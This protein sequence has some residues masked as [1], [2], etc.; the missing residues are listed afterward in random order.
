MHLKTR[1]SR[2]I[3]SDPSEKPDHLQGA[4]QALSHLKRVRL[5]FLFVFAPGDLHTYHAHKDC[6][7]PL[8]EACLPFDRAF[9]ISM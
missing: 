1:R 9:S 5:C 6:T 2:P 4:P 7:G 3:P 8:E